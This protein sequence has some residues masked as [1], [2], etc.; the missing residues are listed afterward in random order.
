M[1]KQEFMEQLRRSLAS[2][3]DYAFVNDTIAYYENYIESRIRMGKTEEEVMQELG[4]PRLIAKSIHATRGSNP[5]MEGAGEYE[6]Y[7]EHTKGKKVAQTLLNLNGRQINLPSWLVKILVI[8]IVFVV[9]WLV[10]TILSWLA[11]FII[12]G[13]VAYSIYKLILNILR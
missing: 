2:I 10:F 8:L 12:L 1:N 7:K 4:D 13:I 9:V 11:P 5:D 3:N 6:T